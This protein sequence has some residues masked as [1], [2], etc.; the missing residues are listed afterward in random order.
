MLSLPGERGALEALPREWGFRGSTRTLP[1]FVFWER[2]LSSANSCRV[3]SLPDILPPPPL[4]RPT[5]TPTLPLLRRCQSR[6]WPGCPAPQRAQLV[7]LRTG[8]TL[9]LPA[10]LAAA[11]AVTSISGHPLSHAPPR[12]LGHLTPSS[13]L[14]F[15]PA[16]PAHTRTP[17]SSR[18]SPERLSPEGALRP[19]APPPRL[20]PPGPP[21]L[22]LQSPLLRPSPRR[23]KGQGP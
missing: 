15:P 3:G 8:L 10:P 21:C 2:G 18:L 5:S 17:V 13:G 23:P 6:V 19:W 22:G 11:Q 1:L 14:P 16:G 20:P 7:L 9:L 4:P 12:A